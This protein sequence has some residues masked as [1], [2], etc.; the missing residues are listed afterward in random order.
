MI[1]D[2]IAVDGWATPPLPLYGEDH[3]RSD[4]AP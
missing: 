4:F 2:M 1:P 3:S